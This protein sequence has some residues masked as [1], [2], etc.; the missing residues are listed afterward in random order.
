MPIDRFPAIQECIDAFRRLPGIGPKG[1]Q[2]I[3]FHLLALTSG[4]K[5]APLSGPACKDDNLAHTPSPV[6]EIEGILT[7]IRN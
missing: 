2:R 6:E 4:I 1:A 5:K 3:V 7:L